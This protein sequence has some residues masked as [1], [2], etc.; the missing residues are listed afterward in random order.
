MGKIKIMGRKIILNREK[1]NKLFHMLCNSEPCPAR[2]NSK[3]MG[4]NKKLGFLGVLFYV[5]WR[6]ILAGFVPSHARASGLFKGTIVFMAAPAFHRAKPHLLTPSESSPVMES[7]EGGEQEDAGPGRSSSSAWRSYN[8]FIDGV[9]D[10][11]SYSQIRHLF[12][13]YGKVLNLFIQKQKK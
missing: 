11:V 6:S 7:G 3:S 9:S 2:R 4:K 12:E 1:F 5:T 10:Y 13:Q 8:L